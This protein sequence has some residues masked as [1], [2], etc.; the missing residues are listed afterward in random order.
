LWFK[1]G[2]S[3]C[4]CLWLL[5]QSRY[6]E[7]RATSPEQRA[8]AWRFPSSATSR[9]RAKPRQPSTIIDSNGSA[10]ARDSAATPTRA[11]ASDDHDPLSPSRLN[12]NST[13]SPKSEELTARL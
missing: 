10:R 12:S 1:Q 11:Q 5:R 9:R 8:A 7:T 6:R 3:R 4:L 13:R 2:W